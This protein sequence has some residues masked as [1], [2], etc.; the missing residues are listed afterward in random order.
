[1]AVNGRRVR[2]LD[3]CKRAIV[4]FIQEKQCF[5][6]GNLRARVRSREARR[7]VSETWKERFSSEIR[8]CASCLGGEHDFEVD[9]IASRSTP[10][11]CFCFRSATASVFLKI[12]RAGIMHFWVGRAECAEVLGGDMGRL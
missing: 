4:V 1:M 3:G 2:V 7:D 9:G 11:S 10:H 8:N 5:F 6:E 12:T